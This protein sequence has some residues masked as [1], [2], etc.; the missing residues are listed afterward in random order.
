[1][2][3]KI[4]RYRVRA[5]RQ[6][7]YDRVQ[8]RAADVYRELGVPPTMYYRSQEDPQVWIE[9]H[10]YSDAASYESFVARAAQHPEIVRLWSDFEATLD[11]EYPSTI[12]D[13]AESLPAESSPQAAE[14]GSPSGVPDR[15]RGESERLPPL[16]PIVEFGPFGDSDAADDSSPALSDNHDA[17]QDLSEKTAES[18]PRD[19]PRAYPPDSWLPTQ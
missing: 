16:S 7:L 10:R 11:R 5:D 8:Q 13:F 9:V 15:E 1:M 2:L 19:A 4:Y 3:V 17:R 14:R 18:P 6:P 12:E